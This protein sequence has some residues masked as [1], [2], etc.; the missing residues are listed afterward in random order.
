[1]KRYF[2]TLDIVGQRVKKKKGSEL[3]HSSKISMC[4]P[5]AKYMSKRRN[6]KNKMG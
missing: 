2:S 4:P 6:K 1:M 3:T 5:P